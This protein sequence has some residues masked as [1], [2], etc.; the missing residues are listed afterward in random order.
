MHSKKVLVSLLQGLQDLVQAAAP[1]RTDRIGADRKLRCDVIVG[2]CFRLGKQRI[3]QVPACGIEFVK[4]VTNCLL[5]FV[6]FGSW[7]IGLDH[8]GGVEALIAPATVSSGHP[9]GLAL[10]RHHDPA[11]QGGTISQ[12]WE[13]SH[14]RAEDDLG[15]IFGIGLS[16]AAP[17]T[18]RPDQRRLSANEFRPGLITAFKGGFDQFSITLI[19][20][21]HDKSVPAAIADQKRRSTKKADHGGPDDEDRDVDDGVADPARKKAPPPSEA[22]RPQE[23]SDEDAA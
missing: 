10:G 2:R 9:P 16:K 19:G 15:D 6:H 8:G 22:P 1:S 5:S 17:A 14:H 20:D 11:A 12:M 13:P 7:F 3:E 23:S 18:D 21:L 4:S